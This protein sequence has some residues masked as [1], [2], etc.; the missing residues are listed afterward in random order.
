M[1][2]AALTGNQDIDGILWGVRWDI[3][4]LT[5]GFATATNQYAGYQ[6]GSIQGFAAFNATQKAAVH[7]II[8]Q[9]NTIVTIGVTFTNDPTAAN[10]RFAEATFVDQDGLGNPGTIGTAV[11]TPPDTITFPAYG[12]GDMFFNR[13]DY[14]N[15]I[16][17]NFAYHTLIH[18]LGHALGLKHGH[19]SQNYPGSAV[20][21]PALPNAHDSMEF[22]VMT[23]RSK[24]GG[25]T[26]G[27]TNETFGYAQSWMMNDIAALQYLYG[28][29][30]TF[31]STDTTYSWSNTTGEM[32]FNGVGQGAPGAN[33]IFLTTW[34]GGGEDTYDF[35]NYGTNLR[36]D[37][38]PGKFSVTANNQL[39]VLDVNTNEKARG[40]IFNA[41]LF[42][43]DTRSLIEN[44]NGGTG[45]DTITGN[46]A[47]NTLVGD[48]G[49]DQ[50]LGLTGNDE[51]IGG[52]G[53][54]RLTGGG[55]ND[56][57]RGDG[58]DDVLNGGAGNDSL[59]GGLGNDT[60]IASG[61]NDA[62]NGSSG[63][64]SLV[65]NGGNDT[66]LGGAGND[67]L[68]GGTGRDA[69]NGNT[70]FDTFDFNALN[71]STAGAQRDVIN[72]FTKGQDVIDLS[73]IDAATGV[74][75][76]QAFDFIGA[77]AFTGDE[78]DLRIQL[79]GSDSIVEGDVDGDK[80]ADFSILV[81]AV[82]NLGFGDF[83]L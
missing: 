9:L 68:V 60:V 36:V 37:L 76:D 51:L 18:E 50:L 1:P 62:A 52:S 30:F 71:E 64:D 55:G 45:N 77:L 58:D 83:V 80:I 23:Y 74:A 57:L 43:N 69:L 44:A 15:P 5:Y 21:I 81:T 20:V 79:S 42:N 14:N 34:D 2:L 48:A 73:T 46:T 39:A 59:D 56:T 27:Y 19:V 6:V 7:S 32:F 29:D 49:R 8:A 33:R 41:L 26:T 31:N 28:A 72:G 75:G 61:G 4:S 63:N 24:V 82:N 17:G 40:N 38:G 70:G 3:P 53:L 54:D 22:S 67:T 25:P 12:H 13:T 10:L 65:G 78:G 35:S 16:K 66:L 11:G 47:D